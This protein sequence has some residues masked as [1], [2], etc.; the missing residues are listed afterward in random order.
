[1]FSKKEKF[2]VLLSIENYFHEQKRGNSDEDNNC[3]N[4]PTF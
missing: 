1:M 3:Q 4:P 2:Y